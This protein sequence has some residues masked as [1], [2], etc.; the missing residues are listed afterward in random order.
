MDRRGLVSG[1]EG[2]DG[3]RCSAYKLFFFSFL[4]YRD[5]FDAQKRRRHLK[6]RE[7]EGVSAVLHSEDAEQ[8]AVHGEHDTAPEQDHDGLQLG[9]LDSGDLEGEGD[10]CKS[11]DAICRERQ[12]DR[13]GDG[14]TGRHTH[15]G[16]NLG[17]EAELVLET[18]GKV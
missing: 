11:E 5:G 3:H 10:C 7:P 9:V 17:F 1:K 6:W 4:H 12:S 16:D 8:E 2:L 18:A 15:G 13:W 14:E